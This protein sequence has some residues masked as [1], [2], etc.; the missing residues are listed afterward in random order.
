MALTSVVLPAPLGPIRPRIDP[1]ST[2]SDTSS[3]ARTPPKCRWTF[4][5]RRSTDLRARPPAWTDE[6][7]TATAKDSLRA[8]D[9]DKDQD[10]AADHTDVVAC[11][12][13]DVGERR[14]EQRADDRTEHGAAAAEHCKCEDLNGPC[15]AVLVGI[16]E[17]VE[18]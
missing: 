13:E 2:S 5:S 10:Q 11:L 8:E 17:E 16:D 6:G 1:F 9:D 18:V 14:Q 4:S 15:H 3:T 7:E 12:L